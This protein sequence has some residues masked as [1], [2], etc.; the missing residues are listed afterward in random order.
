MDNK[1]FAK[2]SLKFSAY[3]VSQSKYSYSAQILAL[4][5]LQKD[6]CCQSKSE[7]LCC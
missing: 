7:D 3:L 1:D 6:S 5:S 4:L 2:F